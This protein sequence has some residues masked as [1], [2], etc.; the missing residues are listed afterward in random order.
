MT[1]TKNNMDSHSYRDVHDKNILI[2]TLIRKKLCMTK[3][4]SKLD[5][6]HNWVNQLITHN[7]HKQIT[8]LNQLV[9]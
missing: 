6:T 3:K 2:W 9:K 8:E 5:I 1:K 4:Y 7:I